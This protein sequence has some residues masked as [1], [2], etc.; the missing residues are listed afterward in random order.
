[1]RKELIKKPICNFFDGDDFD[2]SGKFLVCELVA[3]DRNR[4]GFTHTRLKNELRVPLLST[5]V[6]D[7]T[8]EKPDETEAPNEALDAN[9]QV[10]METGETNNGEEG[11]TEVGKRPAS[12][13]AGASPEKE[14]IRPNPSLPDG[15][16]RVPNPGAGKA[17]AQGIA[18][19]GGGDH[20]HRAVRAAAV[21]HLN[22]HKTK[23]FAFWD[24]KDCADNDMP[25]KSMAGFEQYL[26]QVGAVHQWAGNLE[27]TAVPQQWIGLS[28]SSIRLGR[29]ISLMLPDL[30]VKF[31]FIM[32]SSVTKCWRCP[33]KLGLLC[34]LR[35]C[36][37]KARAGEKPNGGV[38][39]I[40]P[41]SWGLHRSVQSCLV[42]WGPHCG[43]KPKSQSSVTWRQ[44]SKDATPKSKLMGSAVMKR[45][46][47]KTKDQRSHSG[48]ASSSSF[49]HITQA[50][51]QASQK[52][53]QEINPYLVG[54]RK[55]KDTWTCKLCFM[56]FHAGTGKLTLAQ[57]RSNHIANRHPN[58]R[59]KCG[60]IRAYLEPVLASHHIPSKQRGW[61]C[62]FCDM[63]LPSLPKTVK[64]ASVRLHYKI[65]HPRR[66]IEAGKLA[67]HRWKLAMKDPN[68]VII[69]RD[70]KNR[71]GD[72]LRRRAA[73][74]LILKVKG[75]H[76][77]PVQVNWKTWP[78]ASKAGRTGDALVTCKRCRCIDGG[79]GSDGSSARGFA[80][81]HGPIR[82]LLGIELKRITGRIFAMH[83]WDISICE[84][85]KWFDKALKSQKVLGWE[86]DLT[87]EGIRTQ[88]RPSLVP[89]KLLQ[90]TISQGC[91]GHS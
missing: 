81:V 10:S 50:E 55:P 12:A 89:G 44:N 87:M 5:N 79:A 69:Y 23:Y 86:R 29:F 26:K 48:A 36:Q 77:V 37:A 32:L 13:G 34:I 31:F 63:A 1:M 65:H 3:R 56:Q 68:K 25:D 58:E 19:S 74:R 78:R 66:K 61:V 72:A 30:I 60:T 4:R 7:L 47:G 43:S 80:A 6:V 21:S 45:T 14:K 38:G 16:T 91:L 82:L 35:P 2:Q 46:L 70:C 88:P 8:E 49:R 54:K 85:Q 20:S 24:G 22:R 9:G 39:G 57:Q 40:G 18:K 90:C 76:V 75:H 41:V 67:A 33:R 62:P 27:I 83:G 71:L 15:V 53:G 51:M 84:A 64:E 52:N 73:E 59:E 28:L 42:S 11:D 17:I